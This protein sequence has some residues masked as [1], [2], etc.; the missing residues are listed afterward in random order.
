MVLSRKISLLKSIGNSLF[1]NI[2]FLLGFLNFLNNRLFKDL[3]ALVVE[4]LNHLSLGNFLT[5]FNVA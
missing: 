1:Q 4:L 3:K 2:L 5:V